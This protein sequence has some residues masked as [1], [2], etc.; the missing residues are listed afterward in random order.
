MLGRKIQYFE[1]DAM[2]T[3]ATV[4]YGLYTPGTSEFIA[5]SA[6]HL[7]AVLAAPGAPTALLPLRPDLPIGT[8]DDPQRRSTTAFIP[9]P[10]P[11]TTSPSSYSTGTPMTHL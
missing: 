3:V 4:I 9:P 10:P 5:S 11:P 6:G 2:A 7:P 8:A 1:P